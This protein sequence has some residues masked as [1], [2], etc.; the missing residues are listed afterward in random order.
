MLSRRWD[1]T[2]P[3]SRG[4]DQGVGSSVDALG[5]SGGP[6]GGAAAACFLASFLAC[7]RSRRS[8]TA[9]SRLSFAIVVFFLDFEA[10]RF[11]PC[12][13]VSERV[14][15]AQASRYGGDETAGSAA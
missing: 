4:P 11:S 6:L 15:D 8:R 12:L 5:A 2:E 7:F 10:M 3:P 9:F 14:D 13:W 1:P